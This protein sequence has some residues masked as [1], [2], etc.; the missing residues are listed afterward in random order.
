MNKMNNLSSIYLQ[1]VFFKKT[2]GPLASLAS[3]RVEERDEKIIY[4]ENLI[5]LNLRN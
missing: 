3:L 4:V 5:S 2:S 1:L